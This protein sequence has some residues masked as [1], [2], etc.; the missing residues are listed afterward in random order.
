[1]LQKKYQNLNII[2]G[3]ITKK[4]YSTDSEVT[5][6][7]RKINGEQ[8]DLYNSLIFIPIKEMSKYTINLN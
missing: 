7:V 3:A 6:T 5:K 4:T 8:Y 2:L 1:M